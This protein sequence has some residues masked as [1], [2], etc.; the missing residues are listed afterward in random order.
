[1]ARLRHGEPQYRPGE[2][3]QRGSQDL[4]RRGG[5]PRSLRWDSYPCSDRLLC[6][7]GRLEIMRH[8]GPPA[9]SGVVDHLAAVAHQGRA[10]EDLVFLESAEERVLRHPGMPFLLE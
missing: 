5:A 8:V 10:A 3:G 1:V 9:G 4:E 2:A 7:L 6:P